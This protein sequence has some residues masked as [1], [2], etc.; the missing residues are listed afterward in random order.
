[1]THQEIFDFVWTKLY[2]QGEQSIE[3]C[4]CRYRTT[5]GLKCAVG[6]LIPDDLYEENMEGRTVR[7]ISEHY[8][9]PSD[10]F[11]RYNE[12]FL[13]ELQAAHDSAG[14]INFLEH[15]ASQMRDIAVRMNLSHTIIPAGYGDTK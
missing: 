2:E 5:G 8:S 3:R 13:N 10:V 12:G 9:L 1:M 14:T 7:V 15:L 4:D 11:N 6:H